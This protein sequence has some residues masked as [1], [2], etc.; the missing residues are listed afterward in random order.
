MPITV[1]VIPSREKR[2]PVDVEP[3]D[4]QQYIEH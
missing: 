4:W 2:I 3:A 1:R